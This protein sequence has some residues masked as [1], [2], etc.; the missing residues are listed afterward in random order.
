MNFDSSTLIDFHAHV[1]KTD[2]PPTRPWGTLLSL[3]EPSLF[4]ALGVSPG[5][6]AIKARQTFTE[7]AF[8]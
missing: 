2:L 5:V 1:Y 7:D 3:F 8:T 4:D 6:A